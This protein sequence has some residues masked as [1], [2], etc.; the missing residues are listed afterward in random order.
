MEGLIPATDS[1]WGAEYLD[2][3]IAVKVVDDLDAAISHI[4]KYGSDHTETIVTR[5]YQ[6]AQ[7]FLRRVNS[8][9]VM[10]N[11]STRFS[12]GGQMGLG[13]EIGIST[14]KLHA[15]G[16]MGL[17]GLTTTKYIIYGNGQIRE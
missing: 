4:V 1:D 9:V 11:A 2:L 16:P 7:E 15:Y 5:D 10:V 13:A 6:Q 8:S 3:I 12:D 17:E 14:T